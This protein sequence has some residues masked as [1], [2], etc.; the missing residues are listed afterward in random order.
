M[1]ANLSKKNTGYADVTLA[2]RTR[3]QAVR[4]QDTA[5]ELRVRRALH[6]MGYRYRLHRKDLPG[7]PDIVL[8]RHRKII[9][10]HG[11]FWHGHEQCKRAKPPTKNIATWQAKI[12]GN[13][14]RDQKN[15]AKLRELGWSVL[16]IWECEVHDPLRVANHLQSFL[17][18]R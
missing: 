16:I 13:R 9:L 5:P 8:P 6:A 4:R 18:E 11:C 14:V 17:S 2:T 7:A 3:M 1:I 10:V 15:V 12:D